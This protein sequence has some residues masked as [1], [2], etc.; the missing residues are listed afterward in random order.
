MAH[1]LLWERAVLFPFSNYGQVNVNRFLCYYYLLVLVGF[2]KRLKLENGG[3]YL[4]DPNSAGFIDTTHTTLVEAICI[5]AG[6]SHTKKSIKIGINFEKIENFKI[7]NLHTI[8]FFSFAYNS[9]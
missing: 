5:Y 8:I 2:L 9:C 7:H 4:D 3:S 1:G 6:Y